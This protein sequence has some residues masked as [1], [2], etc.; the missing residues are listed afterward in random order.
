MVIQYIY[1][2]SLG[3][4]CLF[5]LGGLCMIRDVAK[6]ATS[7]IVADLI[8]FGACFMIMGYAFYKLY[9]QTGEKAGMAKG[10]QP[11]N[12]ESCLM[13]LGMS[14]YAFEGVGVVVPIHQ[15]MKAKSRFSSVLYATMSSLLFVKVGYAVVAYFAYADSPQ[16]AESGGL[17]T[18]ALPPDQIPV[19]IMKIMYFIPLVPSYVLALYPALRIIEKA[20]FFGD[21]ENPRRRYWLQNLC[22][23][24]HVGVTVI[25][26]VFLGDKY[27]YVQAII[28]ALFCAPIAFIFPA[29]FHY[30]LVGKKQGVLTQVGNIGFIIFGFFCL[31]FSAGITVWHGIAG[32]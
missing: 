19:Q 22:R 11:F 28:G 18:E 4:G 16:M 25:I 29:L 14:I 9:G 12:W 23:F 27:D 7:H 30:K 1:I 26:G 31:I 13:F 21:T 20:I 8:M 32:E 6:F 5:I 24:L 2:I 15:Q 10:I 17:V 3:I